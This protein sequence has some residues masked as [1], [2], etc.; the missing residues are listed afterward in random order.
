M[1]NFFFRS[2]SSWCL[3][4]VPTFR[5]TVQWPSSGPIHIITLIMYYGNIITVMIFLS[6]KTTYLKYPSFIQ[7]CV[8]RPAGKKDLITTYIFYCITPWHLILYKT[9]LRIRHTLS[10]KSSLM[11]LS[12][13]WEAAN[14]AAT[15]ELPG[16]LW[17]PKVHCPPL[18]LSW[19]RSIQSI[20]SQPISLRSILILSTHL[21]LGHPSGL[22]PSGFPTTRTTWQYI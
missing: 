12:P 19:A 13:S 22:F 11:E 18:S 16:I 17:N 6:T 21:R 3:K 8:K 2:L 1:R 5:R 4:F 15:Q 14:C 10:R 20:P 7:V 9:S